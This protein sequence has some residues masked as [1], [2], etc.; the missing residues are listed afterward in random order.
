MQGLEARARDLEFSIVCGPDEEMLLG[1]LDSI[2]RSMKD[3]KWSWGV[4][5]T[6]NGTDPSLG[7][8]LRTRFPGFAII[9]NR[10]TKG[11]ADTHNRVLRVSRARYVWILE[12][13]LLILPDT[14]RVITDFL[15]RAQNS[16]VGVAAPQLLNPDGTPQPSAYGFPSMKDVALA[17]LGFPGNAAPRE[18][19]KSA[20]SNGNTVELAGSVKIADVDTLPKTCMVVRTSA[21]RQVGPMVANAEEGSE[22]MEWHRRFHEQGW[23][24]SR[25]LAATVIHYGGQAGWSSSR[26]TD[27]Q[28]LERDLFF[29]RSGRRSATYSFF[30]ASLAVTFAARAGVA[31]LRR[32]TASSATARR[33]VRLALNGIAQPVAN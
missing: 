17:H 24:V 25:C 10:S 18:V 33:C 11:F 30:C 7:H 15:D 32:D 19:A 1:L 31:W 20:T 4:T 27:A 5:V 8:R 12:D 6:C 13:D 23:R 21:L 28:R 22:T 29:F 16:R 26:P 2:K 3:A 14:V 9:E